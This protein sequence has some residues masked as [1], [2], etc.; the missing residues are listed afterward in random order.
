MRLGG[1]CGGGVGDDPRALLTA[2]P[3]SEASLEPVKKVVTQASSGMR[4]RGASY[5]SGRWL[6]RSCRN[7]SRCEPL[8]FRASVMRRNVVW[9]IPRA[10]ASAS[11][12]LRW[13]RSQSGPAL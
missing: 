1:G 10:R 12:W 2:G 13:A 9:V 3:A 7:S 5:C 11:N 8:R 4:H 6:M